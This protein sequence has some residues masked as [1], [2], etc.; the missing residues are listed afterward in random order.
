MK[1]P[2]NKKS[3][4][5]P[6]QGF[7]LL[8]I[9]L[10]M[11]AIA[12]V[13]FLNGIAQNTSSIQRDL[14][15]VQAA[16]DRLIAAKQALLGYLVSPPQPTIRP[17]ALPTPDSWANGNY[18]GKEDA[19]C[20]GNTL[21]GFPGVG[22]NS[23]IKRCLGKIPW[24]DLGLDL[25]DIPVAND[26]TGQVP[27]YAVSANLVTYDQCLSVLNS[28]VANLVSPAVPSCVPSP[29]QP[30]VLPH[31]WLKVFDAGGNLLSDKVAIVLIL[32]GPP[33]ATET[34]V[35]T[36]AS[37]ASPGDPAD[38]L[39]GI[40]L[41]LGCLAG[42]TVFSNAGM[43]NQ[44]VMIPP[45]TRY[46]TTAADTTKR[47]SLVPFN[48]VLIYLTIDEVMSY[49]ERRVVGEMASALRTL[50]ANNKFSPQTYPWLVPTSALPSATTSLVPQP[51]AYFGYFPFMT[52]YAV[53]AN[54]NYGSDFDWSI[55]GLSGSS[56]C[57]KINSSPKRYIS[58][59]LMNTGAP[60][61][62]AAGTASSSVGQCQWKGDKVVDCGL[63]PGKEITNNFSL[64]GVI[65]YS[66]AICTIPA[67]VT[68][69]SV[70]RRMTKLQ[71]Q[72]TCK[73]PPL[74]G[75]LTLAYS[76]GTAGDVHRWKWDCDKIAASSTVTMDVT[77]RISDPLS[78]WDLLPLT[79]LSTSAGI[80]VKVS[81]DRMIYHPI[82]PFWFHENLWYKTAFS[83]VAP[84]SAPNN[85]SPCG[86][87]ITTLT[88]GSVT[89]VE[90]VTAV[91]GRYLP[92][93]A[94]PR[95]TTVI[96]DYFEG[97]N[98]LGK[99]GTA[100]GLTNCTFNAAA[101]AATAIANDQLLVVS[102]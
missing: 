31:P 28:D 47:G 10:T 26:P 93:G 3:L 69:L 45:G 73:S 20:L 89:N 38:Y 32:P 1:I 19:Q 21:N 2:A 46:P 61:N 80:G 8:L 44:F 40:N 76:A 65:T 9:V 6:A 98:A 51:G 48:D 77:D 56:P 94:N 75:T 79:A 102:P 97:T 70:Q 54:A 14:V 55:T 100:P 7:V 72:A 66:D 83:G 13:V 59:T 5:R 64:S 17:G 67:G 35:Q 101:S 34:A 41:P 25:G 52:N 60:P 15:R 87:G 71:I 78:V 63:Q 90:A 99:G 43:N 74:P 50:K 18:D 68:T 58:S 39:D 36:R 84:S 86:G 57:L 95:P 37:I 16:N 33:I 81:M 24:K 88:V 27:W 49:I 4:K 85:S 91:A 22:S 30:T 96:T 11:L 23:T 62:L 42:C 12:G 82:M 29:L 92:T 53:G